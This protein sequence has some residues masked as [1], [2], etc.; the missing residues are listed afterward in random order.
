[1]DALPLRQALM[2]HNNAAVELLRGERVEGAVTQLHRALHVAS[3]LLPIPDGGRPQAAAYRRSTMHVSDTPDHPYLGL[4]RAYTSK[5]DGLASSQS[6]PIYGQG[7][8]VED[9]P[10]VGADARAVKL[11]KKLCCGIVMF[12]L[13][14]VHHLQSIQ[15]HGQMGFKPQGPLVKAKR[16]Y[17]QCYQILLDICNDPAI[18]DG[19]H[20]ANAM[21]DFLIMAVWNNM[22]H[23]CR[24]LREMQQMHWFLQHLA[25]ATSPTSPIRYGTGDE[26]LVATMM[27]HRRSFGVN[28]MLM[29]L[30]DASAGAA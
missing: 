29:Q 16:L 11:D 10:P 2:A 1:M 23:V 21:V 7:L 5:T 15:E 25:H 19:F 17:H 4:L 3:S 22:S 6:V 12:N 8:L 20:P 9:R 13:G 28:A 30:P 14:L 27:E 26:D 18:R 24:E